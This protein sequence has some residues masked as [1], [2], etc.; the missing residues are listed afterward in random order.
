MTEKELA[1]VLKRHGYKLHAFK[2]LRGVDSYLV[3]S[4][5]DFKTFGNEKG[6]TT[7]QEVIDWAKSL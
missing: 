7:L 1:M 2:D 4:E 6:G 5:H 3:S